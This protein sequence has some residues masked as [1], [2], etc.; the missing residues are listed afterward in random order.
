MHRRTKPLVAFMGLLLAACLSGT[1]SAGQADICYSENTSSSSVNTLTNKSTLACPIAGRH[2]LPELAQDGWS[3]A[4]IQS[5]VA[6]Y[7]VDPAT[8]T[9]QSSTTWMVVIQRGGK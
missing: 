1:A 6:E 9:P 8:R 2:T 4:S 7:S 3:V 5:V